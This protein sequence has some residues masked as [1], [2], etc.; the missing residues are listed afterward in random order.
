MIHE[1]EDERQVLP[2]DQ[3]V[4]KFRARTEAQATHLRTHF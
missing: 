3:A 1:T 2:Q 4:M